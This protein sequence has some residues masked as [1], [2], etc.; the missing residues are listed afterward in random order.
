MKKE[1]KV[2]II[3]AGI[4][5]VSI[6]AHLAL[7]K[8]TDV[9]IAEMGD[10]VGGGETA[11][12][13]AMLMF[14][15]HTGQEAKTDLS[16]L[17]IPE[18]REFNETFPGINRDIGLHQC[19]SI[20]YAT[21][22]V[23]AIKLR[24][25]GTAQNKKGI[26]TETLTPD[27]LKKRLPFA[28][29]SDIIVA[30]YCPDD[31][32]LDAKAVVSGYQDYARGQGVEIATGLAATGIVLEGDQVVGVQTTGGLIKTSLVVNAAGGLADKVGNWVGLKIPL[33]NT[34]RSIWVTE[35]IPKLGKVPIFEDVTTEWYLRPA[36]MQ[37]LIGVGPIDDA[38]KD[39]KNI[40]RDIPAKYKDECGEFIVHR[41]PGLAGVGLVKGWAGMRPLTP[42]QLPIIGPVP[43]V[44]GFINCCGWSGYGVMHAPIAGRL[45]AELIAHGKTDTLDITPFL[46]SRFPYL[47]K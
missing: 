32:Y 47:S 24:D 41:A 39:I 19:G 11:R 27:E 8:I 18:Y 43:E 42:D 2:V 22:E 4:Q 44:R 14:Q 5:G 20:L 12:T 37:L 30:I 23:A 31:G 26:L 21:N 35:E 16:R 25:Q 38:P 45:V 9:V 33:R 3:G 10:F 13:A 29:V 36:G 1:A 7:K 15:V 46:L 34:L 40:Q 17:S 6:A 28:N